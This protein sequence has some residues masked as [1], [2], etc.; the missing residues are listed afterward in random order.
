MRKRQGQTA[1]AVALGLY[2]VTMGVLGGVLVERIRYD[3]HRA[4]V[5]AHYDAA[6]KARNAKLIELE[7]GP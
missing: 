1:V 6:L 2:L 5:L 3:R 4:E 7:I